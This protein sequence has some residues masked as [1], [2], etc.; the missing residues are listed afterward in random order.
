MRFRICAWTETSRAEVGSS[1]TMKSAGEL[2]RV[3]RAVVRVQPD[4]AEEIADAV[5]DR[6]LALDEPESPDRLGDDAVDAPARVE[7]RVW[8]LEDHLDTPAQA[9]ALRRGCR[10]GH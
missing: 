2:V 3:F 5:A 4:E 6:P 8:I 1:Q 10:V 9:L 7:A